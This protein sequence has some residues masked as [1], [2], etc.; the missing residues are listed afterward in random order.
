M[1]KNNQRSLFAG[2][3][4]RNCARNQTLNVQSIFGRENRVQPN[5]SLFRSLSLSLHWKQFRCWI[6][7]HGKQKR[8]ISNVILRLTQNRFNFFF[9]QSIAYNMNTNIDTFVIKL[10][11]KREREKKRDWH[12]KEEKERN[13]PVINTKY[14]IFIFSSSCTCVLF[15]VVYS[16]VAFYSLFFSHTLLSIALFFFVL[17]V[18]VG[19]TFSYNFCKQKT[20]ALQNVNCTGWQC[21][22]SPTEI[23]SG[24][25]A[26]MCLLMRQLR[27][28]MGFWAKLRNEQ[29]FLK[30]KNVVDALFWLKILKKNETNG[31]RNTTSRDDVDCVERLHTRPNDYVVHVDSN[32]R[33]RILAAV[34]HNFL[35]T[36]VSDGFF[37]FFSLRTS[38]FSI[39][40]SIFFIIS[41]FSLNFVYI[42]CE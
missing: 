29:F 33:C 2:R 16:F 42:F 37:S 36:Y 30:K 38:Q 19:S 1:K 41:I 34:A 8:H 3:V 40:L 26:S 9:C 24:S 27:W 25:F 4:A 11:I 17:V 5:H 6:R 14:W 13:H 31:N 12:K 28:D 32:P 15:H 10:S 35:E 39:W 21:A 22:I 23:A 18:V 20:M 7:K